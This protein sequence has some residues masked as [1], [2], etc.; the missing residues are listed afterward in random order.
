MKTTIL[1]GGTLSITPESD[2]EAFALNC[3]SRE[4][5]TPDWYSATSPK[6]PK[7]IIDMSDYAE[8]MGMFLTIGGHGAR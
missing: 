2:L 1:A 7:I 5:I 8:R 6:A 3:W 4:N